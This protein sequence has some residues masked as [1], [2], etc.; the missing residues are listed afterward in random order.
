[1]PHFLSKIHFT[2]QTFEYIYNGSQ[3]S[4]DYVVIPVFQIQKEK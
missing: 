3:E 4:F 2:K 1:M